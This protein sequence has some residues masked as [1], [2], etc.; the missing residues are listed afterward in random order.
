MKKKIILA[1]LL[2]LITVAIFAGVAPL[3]APHIVVVTIGETETY[4]GP[5]DDRDIARNWAEANY[6]G[7]AEWR[8]E[9]LRKP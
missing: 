4:Y 5:F 6:E 3:N 9:H 2:T 7:V 8:L 1:V